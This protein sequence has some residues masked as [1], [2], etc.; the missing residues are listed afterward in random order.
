MAVGAERRLRRDI[1]PFID[2][3]RQHTPGMLAVA[4]TLHQNCIA[5]AR[6]YHIK[7]I[8]EASLLRERIENVAAEAHI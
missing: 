7:A 5:R 3:G 4:R 2:S 8:T 1:W 6:G